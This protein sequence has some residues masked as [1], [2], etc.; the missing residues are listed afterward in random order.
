MKMKTW[1][2]EETKI[3]VF[4][5]LSTDEEWYRAEGSQEY[6]SDREQG[7][8]RMQDVNV[9]FFFFNMLISSWDIFIIKVLWYFGR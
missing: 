1:E 3:K 6:K 2:E 8:E 7:R 9:K 5:L 4:L